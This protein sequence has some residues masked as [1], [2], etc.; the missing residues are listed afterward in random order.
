MK[1]SVFRLLICIFLYTVFFSNELLYAENQ[2]KVYQNDKFRTEIFYN[3]IL[4]PGD[5]VFVKLKLTPLKR[6]IKKLIGGEIKASLEYKKGTD[7]KAVRKGSFYKT[8]FNK[9]RK[10]ETLLAFLPS[11][12]YLSEGNYEITITLEPWNLNENQFTLP[13]TVCHKDFVS[14]TIPLNATN[15]AIKTNTSKE[16]QNQIERLNAILGTVNQDAVY[17]LTPFIPPTSATRRTSFFADRRVYA[18]SN[19]KSSTSLH[20]GIDYGIPTGSEVRACGRGKVVMAEDRISTGWS[21]CIEHLPG[22]YSLYYHMSRLD[23]E[24][25]QMVEKGELLGLSG[26]TGLATGPHLHWEIRLNMEAVNP[27]FFTDDFAFMQAFPGTAL[28]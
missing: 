3:D 27:D 5:A 20:Y 17:E 11:S 28:H 24:P 8:D 13:L 12:T 9:K 2:K 25:G 6:K 18:Y 16:R 26:A 23:V 7:E 19:G 14:E 1:K 15:T 4:Y 21:V 10:A 22:L